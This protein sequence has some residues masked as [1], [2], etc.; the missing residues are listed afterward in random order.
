MQQSYNI[1]LYNIHMQAGKLYVEW[2][3]CVCVYPFTHSVDKPNIYGTP[4]G[5]FF[6]FELKSTGK[7]SADPTQLEF[8]QNIVQGESISKHRSRVER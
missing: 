2:I 3:S 6:E 1:R 7:E 8:Q 5:A 4:S